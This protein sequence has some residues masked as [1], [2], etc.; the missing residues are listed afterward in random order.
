[1]LLLAMT[2]PELIDVMSTEELW[3]S[4]GGKTPA[5][6]LYAAISRDIK[7]K[8]DAS[9]FSKAERGRFEV[10]I[11]VEEYMIDLIQPMMTG[12]FVLPH[13]KRISLF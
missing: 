2:Y 1:M 5:N 4:P 7:V 13:C 3:T 6:T 11:V 8:G 9:A 12:E 10:K